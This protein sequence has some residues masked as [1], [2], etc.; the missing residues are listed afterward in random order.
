VN[1]VME[2]SG[3]QD[4]SGWLDVDNGE[5]VVPRTSGGP[6]GKLRIGLIVVLAG[7]A[8]SR[9]LQAADSLHSTALH[10]SAH[11]VAGYLLGKPA[12]GGATIVPDYEAGTA[13]MV[14]FSESSDDHVPLVIQKASLLN[15]AAK[16]GMLLAMYD[17]DAG[18][19]LTQARFD[20]L[21]NEAE[22]LVL[23]HRPFIEKLAERLLAA[24]RLTG[25]EI[26]ETLDRVRCERAQKRLQ[27]LEAEKRI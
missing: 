26:Q 13:G 8:A 27:E 22:G 6:T 15:D 24:G 14:R 1:P 21:Q 12:I 7:P 19:D 9:K 10:E 3:E 25:E 2:H 17:P 4:V 5:R 20:V 11:C 16:V 23:R 18:P